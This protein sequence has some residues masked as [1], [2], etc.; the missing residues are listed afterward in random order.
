MRKTP[1]SL[2]DVREELVEIQ[3][4]RSKFPSGVILG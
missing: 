4:K 3:G 1:R 2:A